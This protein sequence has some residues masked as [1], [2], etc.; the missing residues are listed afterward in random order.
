MP[1][2]LKFLMPFLAQ[3]AVLFSS[4]I[5]LKSHLPIVDEMNGVC[6]F[7]ELLLSFYHKHRKADGGSYAGAAESL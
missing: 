5:L 4:Q 6:G 7:V 3:G 1:L 2:Y